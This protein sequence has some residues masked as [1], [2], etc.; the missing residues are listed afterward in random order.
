MTQATT[1]NNCPKTLL[2]SLFKQLGLTVQASNIANSD[3]QEQL[4]YLE[5]YILL[6]KHHVGINVQNIDK[7]LLIHT[8]Y[9]FILL[10]ENGAPLLARRSDQN[11]QYF[12]DNG[13]W[14]PL[15]TLPNSGRVFIIETLPSQKRA[16]VFASHL[17][18]RTKWFG[19]L[20]WLSILS[21]LTGLAIPLFT[22]V[23]YDRVIGG[24]SPSILPNIALG[25]ILALAIYISSRM[26]RAKQVAAASNR[27]ARD[28]SGITFN[29]LLSMP[30]TIL[31]RVGL[32]NH[33][34][35]LNNAEKVRGLISGPGGSGLIDVPFTLIALI[36]I[37]AL[38]GWLVLVP[39]IMLVLFFLVMKLL[40]KYTQAATPQINSEYQN[41][42]N[43]LSRTLLQLKMAGETEG[44]YTQ[45]LRRTKEHCR[46]N[47]IYAKRNGLKEAI[48]H[49]M[50]LLTAL[51]TVFTGI[52]LVLNQSISSGALIACVML[53]WRITGPAQVA[54]ASQQKFTMMDGAIKQ[55]DRFMEVPTEFNELRLDVPNLQKAPPISVKH[56]TLRYSAETQPALSGVSFDVAPGEI[57]AIIGPNG[58]GKSSLLLSIVGI[59]EAQAGYVT[60]DG[61]NLKQFD[62]E[63]L[64]QWVAFSSNNSEMMPGTVA[65]NLRLAKPDAT[66]EELREA[67]Y[68][69]GGKSLLAALDD[70]LNTQL[71]SQ[72]SNVFL[73][74]RG[75]A[76]NL[77]RALLKKSPLLVMDEPISNRNPIAKKA[78][79]NT[80]NK[81]RGNT[82]ILFTS[83]DQELIKQADKVVILD[84]GTVIYA[85]P[86]PNQTE[87]EANTAATSILEASK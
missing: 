10:P 78:F 21:S 43:E 64:R 66:D 52:F 75:D 50:G 63:I 87:D 16:S 58:C 3:L 15:A 86:I 34:A 59:I 13:K 73:T 80:L 8:L 37:A 14:E 70:D 84:K 65:D 54:M 24:Q 9:P 71:I 7:N 22:M 51:A 40:N 49:A 62:P 45:F 41:S 1:Y 76:L 5:T 4:T 57:V 39:I 31:S 33:L 82:T 32:S 44:W 18:K 83:H 25:A 26:L 79:I 19:P 23:V 27:F 68:A 28:L 17:K 6:K 72:G 35:R 67:I 47:F 36:A 46:Q 56:L 30:L 85:G 20:F 60:I 77:T 12:S 81:L 55:F 53:I 74:V 48:A 61:K 38:S 42:L 2:V 11:F 69:A 29:R